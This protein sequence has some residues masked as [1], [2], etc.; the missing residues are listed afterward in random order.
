MIILTQSEL[1]QTLTSDTSGKST[2]RIKIH[3]TYVGYDRVL[4][5]EVSPLSPDIDRSYC[6][7]IEV[8]RRHN[9]SDWG[10]S[11]LYMTE[12]W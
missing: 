2:Q 3:L 4:R 6:H 1:A 11:G 7:V 9:R 12:S 8:N 10:L 5:R